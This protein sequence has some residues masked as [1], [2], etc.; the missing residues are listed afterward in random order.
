MFGTVCSLEMLKMNITNDI[1]PVI[2][3]SLEKPG[4]LGQVRDR[5]LCR[6]FFQ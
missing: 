2:L 5:W 3:F 6:G 4:S 1:K